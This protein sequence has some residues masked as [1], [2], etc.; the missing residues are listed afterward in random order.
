MKNFLAVCAAA[1]LAVSCSH[2]KDTV[3]YPNMVADIDPF[4]IGSVN[5][6]FDQV[7]SSQLKTDTVEVIFYPRENEVVL[8]FTLNLSQY[9]QHWN[10]EGRQLFIQAVTS[11][12]DDFETQKLVN[13]FNKSKAVNRYVNWIK[14]ETAS[15]A[16]LYKVI[17]K[18]A[19][20]GFFILKKL[21]D[22]VFYP[23]LASLY[24]DFMESGLGFSVIQ[25][26]IET[27]KNKNG[28]LISTYVSTNNLS[29]IKI[30]LLLGFEFNKIDYVYIKHN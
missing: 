17:Y 12:M 20:I 11:Y 3:K 25:K 7:F 8:E 24:K 14:D 1:M 27:V 29:I 4:P 21:Q 13:N 26:F 2:I 23:F 28:R 9:R 19:S 6:S 30:H 15:G 18:G 10:K 5:A 16:E 22:N